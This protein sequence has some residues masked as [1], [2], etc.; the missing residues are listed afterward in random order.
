MHAF[1]R[2]A[3]LTWYGSFPRQARLV[4]EADLAGPDSRF[5]TLDG[6]TVHYKVA[7]P[8]GGG[9]LPGLG[10]AMYHG[11]GANTFSWSFVDRLLAARL[12]ALVT[13]HDMPGF[14]LTQR[15][16]SSIIPFWLFLFFLSWFF[17]AVHRPLAA[18][19]SAQGIASSGFDCVMHLSK[20]LE[21]VQ[22]V[23]IA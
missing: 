20:P 5:R 10:I 6:V 11:F 17:G 1:V 3:P 2:T 4:S 14:G 18:H 8:K 7:R 23:A 15:C 9:Q 19:S 22:E 12:G 13:A 16:A 21:Q